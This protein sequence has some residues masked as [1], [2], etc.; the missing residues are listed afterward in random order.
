MQ[1]DG[2]LPQ[3]DT[4]SGAQLASLLGVLFTIL[5]GVVAPICL[6]TWQALAPGVAIRS[7]DVG[8]FISAESSQGGFFAPT[9]TNVH[10][11]AGS[12]T[13]L[14]T[15]SALRGR[16]LSVQD[17][18]KSGLHL[19]VT[20]ATA[21]CVRLAGPWTEGLLPTSNATKVFNFYRYGLTSENFGGWLAMGILVSLGALVMFGVAFGE[22]RV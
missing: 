11:T 22:N 10:T 6:W 14:G 16:P 13:V 17:L 15:F 1:P 4:L 3:K 18:N 12:I 19:C 21:S 8:T 20:D 9:L 2:K 7:A 5:L